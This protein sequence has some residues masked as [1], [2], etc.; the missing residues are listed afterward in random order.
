M[1]CKKFL[2]AM[3]MDYEPDYESVSTM[4]CGELASDARVENQLR[5]IVHNMLGF[6]E[7][8]RTVYFPKRLAGND[9]R[10]L[11]HAKHVEN[12]ERDGAEE[13]RSTVL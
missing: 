5:R 10:P 8:E 2:D 13:P 1:L 12:A 7:I 4:G 6:V 3:L 11:H 9:A